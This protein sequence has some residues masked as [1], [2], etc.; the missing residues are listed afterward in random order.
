MNIQ[1]TVDELIRQAGASAVQ[2]AKSQAAQA[3]GELSMLAYCGHLQTPE[4]GIVL[5]DGFLSRV[6]AVAEA[7]AERSIRKMLANAAGVDDLT[8]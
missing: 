1:E 2:K 3:S 5:D 8:F 7:R 6:A 4:T